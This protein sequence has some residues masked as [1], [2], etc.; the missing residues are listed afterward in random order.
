LCRR[1]FCDDCGQ[2]LIHRDHRNGYESASALGQ[3]IHRMKH[4][5]TVG[6]ID[7]YYF[8]RALRLLRL[9]E[10]KQPGQSRKGPQNEVLNL[11][12]RI[13]AHYVDC[14][15]QLHPHSG[16]YVMQGLVDAAAEGRHATRLG[17]PQVVTNERLDSSL[18]IA[19]ELELF[20]WLDGWNL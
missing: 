20:D 6:D 18:G 13:I 11:L 9:L 15:G 1:T 8:K 5:F 4:T 7:L 2:E 3:I 10:H 19:D 17:G 14:T 12:D 16:V